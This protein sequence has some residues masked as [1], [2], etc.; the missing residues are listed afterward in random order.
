MAHETGL[1]KH[2][3]SSGKNDKVGDAADIKARG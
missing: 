2:W 3:A 1:L